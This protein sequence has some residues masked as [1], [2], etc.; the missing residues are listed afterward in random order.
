MNDKGLEKKALL[1]LDNAPSHPSSAVLQSDN[2]MIKTMMIKTMFLPPNTIAIIQPMDQAV[3]DPCKGR[4]KRKLLAHIILENEST[5]KPVPEILK[6]ITMK[7]VVYWIAAAWEEASPESLRK[8]WR[9]LLHESDPDD[10]VSDYDDVS[11]D[12]SIADAVLTAAPLGKDTE[13]A[14]AKWMEEDI[15]EPGHQVLDDDEIVAEMLECE[16]DHDEESSDEEAAASPLVTASKAFDALDVT[17]RWLEQTGA[18]ATHLLLVKKWWDEAAQMRF[19][20]LKQASILS[21]FDT[22]M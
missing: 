7:D 10:G 4:Y 18:D 16:E 8:A 5:D 6:A 14:V 9:N 21:Y 3:L 17:L 20:S 1:L 2:G 19:K 11:P 12:S 15:S 13:E 22:S